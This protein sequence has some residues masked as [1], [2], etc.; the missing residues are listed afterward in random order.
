MIPT[1]G[2]R[3]DAL[4]RR[5]SPVSHAQTVDRLIARISDAGLHLFARIDHAAGAGRVGLD[6]P[7]STLL[8][9]GDPE[10]GT[11]LMVEQPDFALELPSRILV[12]TD[13]DGEVL[14]VHHDAAHLTARY[15]LP[16]TAQHRLDRLM[17][18]VMAALDD[19]SRPGP[20]A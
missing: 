5:T 16:A 4:V 11:P 1:G 3:H 6:L 7:P 15:G 12:R 2:A 20:Q 18:L 8:I 10:V 9:F 14:V 13:A 17:G 19:D